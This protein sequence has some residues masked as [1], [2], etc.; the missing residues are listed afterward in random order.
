MRKI[1]YYILIIILINDD[2]NSSNKVNI[3]EIYKSILYYL[4]F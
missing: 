2:I 1:I 4:K 3:L